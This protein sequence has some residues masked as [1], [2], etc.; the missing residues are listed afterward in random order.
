MEPCVKSE[1]DLFQQK[2]VQTSI[3]DKTM[4]GYRSINPANESILEFVLPR[5]TEFYRDLSSVYLKLDVKLI[6]DKK[7]TGTGTDS[8]TEKV[9]C[10]NNLL[11]S[12]FSQIQVTINGR[13]VTGNG[14]CYPLSLFY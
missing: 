14:D 8:K 10:V 2:F 7:I 13:N 3:I 11:H 9:A 6:G 5:T 4:V 1:L 12:L